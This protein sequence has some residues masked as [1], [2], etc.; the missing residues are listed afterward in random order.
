MRLIVVRGEPIEEIA[1][2]PRTLDRFRGVLHAAAARGPRAGTSVLDAGRG[3][4]GL[5]LVPDPHL[6]PLTVHLRPHPTSET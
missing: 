3:L 5:P 2:E 6:P 1:A 4:L